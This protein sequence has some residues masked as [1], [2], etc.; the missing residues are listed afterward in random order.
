MTF[1]TVCKWS[2]HVIISSTLRRWDYSAPIQELF[3]FL[4]I[5]TK[6]EV[7]DAKAS[8]SGPVFQ[9]HTNTGLAQYLGVWTI[10]ISTI[11]SVFFVKQLNQELLGECY[12]ADKEKEKLR[13]T[14]DKLVHYLQVIAKFRRSGVP[15]RDSSPNIKYFLNSEAGWSYFQKFGKCKNL[16]HKLDLLN[17]TLFLVIVLQREHQHLF[18]SQQYSAR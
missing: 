16:I 5:G 6:Q 4:G 8:Y 3:S 7:Q 12:V 2:D 1:W 11:F 13:A 15:I 10:Q 14:T 9:W 18:K 17:E